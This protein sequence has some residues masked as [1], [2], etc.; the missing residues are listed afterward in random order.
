M[1]CINLLQ[2]CAPKTLPFGG[3][4]LLFPFLVTPKSWLCFDVDQTLHTHTYKG[5]SA[6]R[7]P[8]KAT[9]PWMMRHNGRGTLAE[10]REV[11]IESQES[12]SSNSDSNRNRSRETIQRSFCFCCCCCCLWAP[13]A[14]CFSLWFWFNSVHFASFQPLPLWVFVFARFALIPLFCLGAERAHSFCFCSHCHCTALRPPIRPRAV[15]YP[16]LPCPTT[17]GSLCSMF[18]VM[19][20]RSRH[21][22]CRLLALFTSIWWT[23]NTAHSHSHFQIRIHRYTR[24]QNARD[25]PLLFLFFFFPFPPCES[26]EKIVILFAGAV[27]GS[28]LRF[29]SHSLVLAII[30]ITNHCD[31]FFILFISCTLLNSP[32]E[33]IAQWAARRRRADDEQQI[34]GGLPHGLLSVFPQIAIPSPHPLPPAFRYYFAPFLECKVPIGNGACR[35]EME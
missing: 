21:S 32:I 9:W 5:E 26:G 33:W 11:R 3:C 35:W 13:F 8:Q 22:H 24:A 30:S 20:H 4:W 14:F 31:G 19:A 7:E 12:R 15:P 25:I 23:T 6:K 2:F 16:A 18:H 29:L 1:Q 34:D 10:R 17:L 27:T 28:P